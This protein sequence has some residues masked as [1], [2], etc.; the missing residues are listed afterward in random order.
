MCFTIHFT[1]T[2][3]AH[4]TGHQYRIPFHCLANT[5]SATPT[6][7]TSTT[8]VTGIVFE[9]LYT[10][11]VEDF[12]PQCAVCRSTCLLRMMR[13]LTDGQP[14]DRRYFVEEVEREK[15]WIVAYELAI[16]LETA[17][18]WRGEEEQEGLVGG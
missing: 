17:V 13:A 11:N 18:R 6:S 16:E 12:C 3:C 8:S 7:T 1:F 14:A 9:T 2:R 4:G 15:L 10:A 5:C